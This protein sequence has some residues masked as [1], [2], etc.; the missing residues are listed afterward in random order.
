MSKV[1]VK[2]PVLGG[3]HQWCLEIDLAESL[4]KLPQSRSHKGKREV[5]GAGL[6]VMR[7]PEVLQPR[8]IMCL[9]TGAILILVV[10][11]LSK[12]FLSRSTTI[13]LSS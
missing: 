8:G 11:V 7:R 1:K 3:H 12:V 6:S 13:S 10:F 4:C 5:R 2:L 9:G